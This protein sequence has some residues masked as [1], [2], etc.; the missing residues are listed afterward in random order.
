MPSSQPPVL[1]RRFGRA[2]FCGVSLAGCLGAPAARAQ[3]VAKDSVKL[4]QT[5]ALTGALSYANVQLNAASRAVFD[6]VNGKGGVHGRK[7]TLTSIDDQFDA[8]RALENYQRLVNEEKVFAFYGIGGTPSNMAIAPLLEEAKIPHL[9]PISGSDALH[10]PKFR[11][12]FHIRASYGQELDKVV[13]QLV[14]TGLTKIAVLYSKNS[15]GEAGL[16]LTQMVAKK[17]GAELTV[18]IELPEIVS[19]KAEDMAPFLDRLA[20]SGAN[21]IVGFSASQSS[22]AFFKAYMV[23]T[24][25][26]RLPW[27][28][29]SLLA[30]EATLKLAGP[31][32]KGLVVSQVVPYPFSNKSIVAREYLALMK[33]AGV[34]DI[35]FA[36]MEGYIAAR[37]MVEA[38]ERAGKDLT[39]EKFIAALESM[40]PFDLK[41]YS[42]S[43]AN[44]RSGSAFVEL[45][46]VTGDLRYLQ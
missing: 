10:N 17:R 34:S 25:P 19:G 44:S 32:A 6:E 37:V 16:A 33:R 36:G 46:I 29:I 43:F 41:G 27:H 24:G 38:L 3:P 9:A 2:L 39:R 30:N 45:S 12:T 5:A 11:H 21:A 31:V 7:I 22:L 40:K 14:T 18:A 1:R 23:S 26:G 15:F 13:E 28:T 35:G 42:V 20:K 8:K 4:G